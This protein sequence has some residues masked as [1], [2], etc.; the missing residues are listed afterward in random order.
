MMRR[1]TA[2][3]LLPMAAL[4]LFCIAYPMAQTVGFSFLGAETPLGNF[5]SILTRAVYIDA[6]LRTFWMAFVVTLACAV[7]A[8][9]VAYFI[10]RQ[11]KD[12]QGML[13]ML[14]LIPFWVSILVRSFS[15]ISMFGREG[16]V[17]AALLGLGLVDE[18][19][20]MLYSR[21]AVYIGMVQ[22]LLPIQIMNTF[23]AMDRIDEDFLRAARSLGAKPRQAMGSIFIP[24]SMD[25]TV[26]GMSIVFMLACGFFITP[27]L[28]GGRRDAM[29]GNLIATFV[30]NDQIGLA[31]ALGVV[32]LGGALVGVALLRFLGRRIAAAMV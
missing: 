31:A 1:S 15:W 16:I 13:L 30:E 6:I 24:L 26:T 27:A 5:T 4:F 29:L 21:G 32:L 2:W 23:T 14:F 19:L 3:L 9:P 20:Q 11:P 8:Y 22:I 17:N 25:G 18:P 10:Y 28:L 7:V 12:R